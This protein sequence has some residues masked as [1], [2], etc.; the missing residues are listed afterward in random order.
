MFGREA[1]EE[2]T[3]TVFEPPRRYT[4]S[5]ESHGSRYHT[6][7]SFAPTAR[8]PRVA[9][10]F[11]GTPVSFMARVMSVLLR[12][13][14]KSVAKACAKDLDDIK[15]AAERDYGATSASA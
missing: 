1:T 5:A 8:A 4:L 3:V 9:M 11:Q 13:M 2:M 12:P 6:E 10:T 15:A 7:L 14:M